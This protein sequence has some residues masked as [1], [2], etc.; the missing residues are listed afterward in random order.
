MRSRSKRFA[1]ASLFALFVFSMSIHTVGQAFAPAGLKLGEIRG[2]DSTNKSEL[3]KWKEDLEYIKKMLPE[4]HPNLFHRLDKERFYSEIAKVEKE[5]PEMTANRAALEFERI[6]GLARDGH[7]YTSPLYFDKSGFRLFP[8]AMYAFSDG[9]YIRKASPGLEDILGA[10]VV[11]IGKYDVSKAFEIVEPYMSADNEMFAMEYVPRYFG[12]PE[13]LYELGI[14]EH[15]DS[16]VLRLEKEGKVFSKRIELPKGED[17]KIPEVRKRIK[18]WPDARDKAPGET[19]LHLQNPEESKWFRYLPDQKLMYVHMKDVMNSENETLEQFWE[20]AFAEIDSKKPEKL[21]V[22]IRYNG[23]GNNQ[24]V[25]PIIRGII[26][27]PEIDKEGRLF[28]VIGRVTFSAAQNFTN[29]LDIWTNAI[30]VGEPTGSHVNMYGDAVS[31][32]L[33]NSGMRFRISSLFW[34][35]KH[36]ADESKWTTPDLVAELS[37]AD[38]MKNRDPV[39]EK[40]AKPFEPRRSLREI[41]LAEFQGGTLEAFREKAIAFKNDPENKYVEIEPQIEYFGRELIK[42]KRFDSALGMFKLNKEFFPKSWSVYESLGDVYLLKEDRELALKNF[43]RSL[44]LNP[45]NRRVQKK[46]EDLESGGKKH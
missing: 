45:G 25:R 21:V 26:Q 22:D 5:L 14:S 41:A 34:Q 18:D 10:R 40:V 9:I 31:Y 11:G 16:V 32:E 13:V 2:D 28:V 23:G 12:C 8:Y 30:F 7:T 46:M 6:V 42:L 24:L 33:P 27:R 20:K 35:N 17:N 1:A 15:P 37:F 43:R 36:A 19:P 38:Y 44:E 29:M 4:K 3:Q 39:M